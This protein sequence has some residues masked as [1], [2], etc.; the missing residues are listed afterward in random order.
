MIQHSFKLA[1]NEYN[2]PDELNDSA[3]QLLSKAWEACKSAYAPYSKYYVGAA[4]EL[5]NG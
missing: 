3:K 4:L 1:Y 5:E 2:S